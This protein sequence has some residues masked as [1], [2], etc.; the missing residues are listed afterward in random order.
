MR[1]RKC[2][3]LR[4]WGTPN[5]RSNPNKPLGWI[6]WRGGGFY[7]GPQFLLCNVRTLMWFWGG[8]RQLENQ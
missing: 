7:F 4:G 8:D 1:Q 5:V 2:P 6:T 3:G